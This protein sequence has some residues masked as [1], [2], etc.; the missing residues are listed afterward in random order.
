MDF[1]LTEEQLLLRT[2]VEKYVADHGG[3]ERHRRLSRGETGFDP[4]AWAVFAE[5]GW[6]ALPFAE[7]DGGLGGSVTDLMVLCEGLGRGLVR[8]PYLHTVI[9][10]GGLLSDM[11]NAVQRETWLPPLIEGRAQWA[12]ACAE[13]G[14]GYAL[15]AI[16]T[17]A[18]RVGD[19]YVLDGGKIAVLNGHVADRLLVT[20]RRDD[21]IGLFIVDATAPGLSREPFS[22]VDGS[23]GAQLRLVAVRCPAACMLGEVGE[24]TLKAIEASLHRT[25]VAVGAES[26]GAMQVLL[27][28]TVEYC[29]TRE[30]FG[31][32]I[33]KFQA[34]RHRMVD[35]HLKLE[36]TRSLLY[37]AAIQLQE[38]SD[39]AAAACAALKVKLAQAGRF[40]SHE[41][42]QLHG[43]IGL[44]DE[45]VVG[46]LFKRLLLLSKLY[47]DDEYYLEHYLRL[48]AS[49]LNRPGMGPGETLSTSSKFAEG[50]ATRMEIG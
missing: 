34:L 19:E 9:T 50:I 6:L 16:T 37:H 26:L 17:T 14:S 7:A 4:A 38:G 21:A 32:A 30:Q 36:Q 42:V 12:F 8:E 20:A 25:L 18:L 11:G 31:Q 47:G 40:I 45:L 39:E 15:D 29:K 43:G 24:E 23:R 22:A 27:D 44:T 5:L 10:C 35:M 48:G 41:A 1:S 2:S 49:R 3:V 28:A 46:H 13:E 33:G